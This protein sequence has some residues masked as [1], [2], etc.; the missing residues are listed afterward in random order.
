MKFLS[1][2]LVFILLCFSAQAQLNSPSKSLITELLKSSADTHSIVDLKAID[3]FIKT[4]A[5]VNARD[6][7]AGWHVLHYAANSF[8]ILANGLPGEPHLSTYIE[9]IKILLANGANPNVISDD[10]MTPMSTLLISGNPLSTDFIYIKK[11]FDLMIAHKA[12]PNL[13]GANGISGIFRGI[14]SGNAKFIE[15]IL[16]NYKKLK[17]NFHD[18]N[19]LFGNV[20]YHIAV[21]IKQD[22][23]LLKKMLD[24]LHIRQIKRLAKKKARNNI[25]KSHF[26]KEFEIANQE[27]TK[28]NH[29]LQNYFYWRQYFI[30][31]EKENQ[32]TS[33]V[34]QKLFQLIN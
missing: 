34:C 14:R 26:L 28:Y 23:L 13:R 7:A 32:L 20:L 24:Q 16:N 15:Y 18:S 9:A 1:T 8:S 12:N 27:R 3:Q 25:I 22:E 33:K 11:V 6:D 30:P 29:V 4:G 17:L 21:G 5:D 31:T 2:C 19:E 10:G